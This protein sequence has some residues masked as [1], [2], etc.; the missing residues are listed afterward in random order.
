[1]VQLGEVDVLPLM[2]VDLHECFSQPA[3]DSGVLFYF[4]YEGSEDK[5][6]GRAQRVNGAHAFDPVVTRF[7]YVR[8]VP[9]RRC[10]PA[11]VKT[12]RQK[13]RVPRTKRSPKQLAK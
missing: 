7:V 2:R 12:I 11:I 5:P 4:H 3:L 10:H 1:M 8:N 13:K 6:L 9:N